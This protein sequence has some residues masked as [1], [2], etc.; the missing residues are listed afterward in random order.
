MRLL[1]WFR[2]FTAYKAVHSN[3]SLI[4]RL[5]MHVINV[6]DYEFVSFEKD[7]LG[8]NFIVE[9]KQSKHSVLDEQLV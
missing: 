9:L 5:P 1:T 6:A 4:I 8:Q 3:G 7:P 2:T